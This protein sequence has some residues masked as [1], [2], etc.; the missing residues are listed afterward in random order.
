MQRRHD[1][2]TT[3]PSRYAA[4]TPLCSMNFLDFAVWRMDRRINGDNKIL[5]E[6][7]QSQQPGHR[8]LRRKARHGL[9]GVAKDEYAHFMEVK[10]DAQTTDNPVELIPNSVFHAFNA[11]RVTNPRMKDANI[12]A[13][14]NPTLNRSCWRRMLVRKPNIDDWSPF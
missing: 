1:R 14:I 3:R 2:I 13:R 5:E 4:V 10:W 9:K 12:S 6:S 11:E 8:Q 7:A